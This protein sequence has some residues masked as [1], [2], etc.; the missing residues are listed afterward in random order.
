MLAGASLTQ[1]RGLPSASPR[2]RP[3]RHVWEAPVFCERTSV[4]LDVHARS[5]AAGQRMQ[6]LIVLA[7]LAMNAKP[8]LAVRTG[9]WEDYH[10]TQ[11]MQLEANEA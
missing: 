4:G 1:S 7:L 9:N 6:H 3:I 8:M 11:K 2:G 5:V 10:P